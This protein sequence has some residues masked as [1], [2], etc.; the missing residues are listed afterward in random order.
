ML[1]C[2][3]QFIEL[4]SKQFMSETKSRILNLPYFLVLLSFLMKDFGNI[5]SV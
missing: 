1:A 2:Q 5:L 3:Y 4:N